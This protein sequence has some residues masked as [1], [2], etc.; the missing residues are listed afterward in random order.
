MRAPADGRGPGELL[1]VDHGRTVAEALGPATANEQLADPP[2]LGPDRPA[3]PGV[4]PDVYRPV[5]GRA[6]LTRRQGCRPRRPAP[7]RR[8]PACSTR[9]PA[10]RWHRFG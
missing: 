5:L 4:R 6:P 10:R 2:C 9:T 8:P 3:P 7:R 1:L